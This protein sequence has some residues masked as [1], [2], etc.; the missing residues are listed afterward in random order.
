M[1]ISMENVSNSYAKQKNLSN[2]NLLIEGN[3]NNNT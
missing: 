3:E 1:K 2:I